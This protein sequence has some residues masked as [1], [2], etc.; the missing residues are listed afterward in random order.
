MSTFSHI[1]K[2]PAESRRSFADA[3]D[4]SDFW[5]HCGGKKRRFDADFENGDEIGYRIASSF[6]PAKLNTVSS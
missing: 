2:V 4:D 5:D 3:Q 6:P 1:W